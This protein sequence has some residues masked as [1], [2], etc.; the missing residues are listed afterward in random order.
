MGF[1]FFEDDP[2]CGVDFDKCVKDGE[3]DPQRVAWMSQLDSYSEYSQSGTGAHII[4][5]GAL[6]WDLKGRKS[7]DLK[8]ELY[9][10]ARFFV[11]TGDHIPGT[12]REIND[13]DGQIKALHAEVF[14]KKDKPAS[15][16]A[17]NTV[18]SSDGAA[19]SSDQW[20]LGRYARSN[21][22]KSS[23]MW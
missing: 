11:M 19:S 12:P 10:Q 7:T 8:I 20:L 2:Y 14:T 1:V 21:A 15:D 17:P 9:D 3:M 18:A 23:P 5:R 13:R 4:V 6:G 22:V 16:G